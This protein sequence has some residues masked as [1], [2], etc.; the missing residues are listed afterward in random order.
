MGLVFGR[1]VSMATKT[2]RDARLDALGTAIS[3][4]ASNRRKQLKQQVAFGK[5]LLKGR[6]GSERLA[7]ASVESASDLTVDEINDFLT[8][9]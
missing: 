7:Q 8:G 9:D 1:L 5:R 3:T 4:W 6:T 2:E